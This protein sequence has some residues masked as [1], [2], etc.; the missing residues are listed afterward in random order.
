MIFDVL[1]VIFD[2]DGDDLSRFVG[3]LVLYCIVLYKSYG[4]RS[5]DK[6]P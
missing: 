5:R 3:G 2:G 1:W 4:D 6:K